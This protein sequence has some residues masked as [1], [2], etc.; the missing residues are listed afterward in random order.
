[1]V[2]GQYSKFTQ[3]IN[4]EISNDYNN[5]AYLL[6]QNR[7]QSYLIDVLTGRADFEKSFKNEMKW[8]AGTNISDARSNS[9]L[10]IQNYN[11][12]RQSASDYNYAEKIYSAYTQLSGKI[13]KIGYSAGLRME[14]TR[15]QGG[16]QDSLTLSVNRNYTKL[17]PKASVNIPVGETKTLTLGYS[18]SITRPNYSSSSQITTYINPFFEWSHNINISPSITQEVSATVQYKEI[19][20][21]AS[22]YRINNP[23]YYSTEYNDQTNTL[24]MI[25]K[26]YA[27]ESGINLTGTVPFK[28]KGWT[29]TNTLVATKDQITDPAA[30]T[31]KS[32]PYLYFYSNNQFKLPGGYDFMV[33]GW[34]ITKRN[35]GI[36]ERNA[37]AAIDTT[38]TKTFFKKL[39]CSLSYNSIISTGQAKENFNVNDVVSRGVYYLN[40]R[41]VAMSLK[42]AFGKLKDSKYKN[43]DV[44][45]DLNRIK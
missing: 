8:E 44:N 30:I 35:E 12:Q 5:T 21:G 1:F 11:P 27:L 25:D 31:G 20:W 15:V 39:T 3:Q 14:N 43:R 26:N 16:Y 13:S 32:A 42:Y 34:G 18:K 37:M 19:S 28:Y 7:Q 33:S 22:Y 41:E 4:S 45:D 36:F 23:V 40:N 29:S 24:R 10:N 17:F 38:I 2:G 6:S 9:R